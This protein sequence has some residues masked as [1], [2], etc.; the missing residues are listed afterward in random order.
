M[1]DKALYSQYA[2]YQR[3]DR[4]AE[5]KEM[6]FDQF[7]FHSDDFDIDVVRDFLEMCFDKSDQLCDKFE[8][9]L[10]DE[11]A[12]ALAKELLTGEPLYTDLPTQEIHKI[13]YKLV[14]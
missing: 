14:K 12:Y 6:C 13:V 11:E 3:R 9:E 10:T 7:V 1:L 2:N 4:E 8:D 5:L